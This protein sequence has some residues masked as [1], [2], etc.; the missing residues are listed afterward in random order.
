MGI[1]KESLIERLRA[2]DDKGD[3]FKLLDMALRGYENDEPLVAI[4]METQDN[5]GV[6]GVNTELIG[7]PESYGDAA[8]EEDGQTLS[9]DYMITIN[10]NQRFGVI[11]MNSLDNEKLKICTAMGYL[12]GLEQSKSN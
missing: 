6:L 10:E 12:K 7:M 5:D 2:A 11:A 8:T 9:T 3:L 1:T 4:T